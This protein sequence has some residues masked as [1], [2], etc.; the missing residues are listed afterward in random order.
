M[1]R[2]GWAIMMMTG[3]GFC[4]NVTAVAADPLAIVSEQTAVF[5]N[6][7]QRVP[8][9]S[10]VDG[11]LLGNGDV[12]VVNAGPPDDQFF[13]IGKNDFWRS[14][15]AKIV[16][17]GAVRVVIPAL[18]EATYRQEQDLAHAE[19]RG[20]FTKGDLAVQTRSWVAAAENLLVTELSCQ[21]HTPVTVSVDQMIGGVQSV[22]END[23]HLNIGREQLGSGRWYFDGAIDDVRVY[24]RALSAAEI[25]DA[26]AGRRPASGLMRSWPANTPAETRVFGGEPADGKI[27]RALR[28]DGKQTYVDLGSMWITKC[29]TLSARFNAA[30]YTPGS[31]ANYI[32]SKGQWNQAY[33]LGLSDGHIR[34]SV[35]SNYAQT[36]APIELHRWQQVTGVFDGR[37]IDIYVDG[38]LKARSG[39]GIVDREIDEKTGSC[40]FTRR[41]DLDEVVDGRCVTVATRVLGAATR[42]GRE[43]LLEFELGPGR[44]VFLVSSIVSDLD[45]HDPGAAARKWVARVDAHEISRLDAG[46]R[47][48]W[49]AFWAKSFIEIPDKLI[50]KH[51]YGAL[52]ILACCSREGKI[53]P[54][55][56]GNWITTD[57]PGWQGDYTLNYNF[58]APYYITYSANHPEL[59]MPFY[60]AIRDFMPKGFEMART[61]GWKGVH[62]PTHIGPWGLIPEGWQD[63]G[64]RSDAAYAALNFITYYEHTQDKDW[65]KITGYPFLIEVANFWEDYLKFEDGRYVI[66]NDSIHEGSGPDRNGVLSLGLVRTL[67]RSMIRF[68]QDLNLDAPRRA[69]WQE[70]LD[71]LS[72]YPLQERD[73]K[74]VFRYTEKGMDWNGGNGLGIQQIFPGGAIGLGSDPRLLEISRNMISAMARWVD[75]NCFSSFYAAAARVG[76][77]PAEILKHLHEQCERHAFPNLILFYGGGG[78]ESCGGFVVINEMLLQSHEGI[79]RLFPVWPRDRDARFG[80]LL[81]YGAF[82]VSAELKNGAVTGVKI[83]SEKGRDCT[84]QNPWPGKSVTLNRNGKKAE[85]CSGERFTFRT[86]VGETVGM[87]KAG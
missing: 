78:I 68:S 54:G 13:Y 74:T 1:N 2:M 50:E 36:I 32:L 49:A 51:W 44:P 73:G 38:V 40:W 7:P 81:T 41:A 70:I 26:A 18:R 20:H 42:T 8:T 77:D 57:A 53:A 48:W 58:Q 64:Q 31:S 4:G 71:H 22:I 12:G 39:G 76:Y 29:V 55:L 5:D 60:K 25:G 85:T 6:P 10:M 21:G 80:S 84:V 66:E 86:R 43:G 17:V 65:L 9:G 37:E 14:K 47:K 27:E 59:S 75:G 52:Y 35:G 83:L 45:A 72:D 24:D 3:A 61:H 56:W 15:P 11:P 82:L 87:M 28:F 67:F 16:S 46:R 19:V 33:S 30:A 79:I 23:A 69:K 34:M 62:F 63:W